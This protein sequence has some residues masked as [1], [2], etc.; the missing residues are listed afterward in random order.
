MKHK[1][2][3]FSLA[4][5]AA[6]CLLLGIAVLAVNGHVKRSAG[7][8][9]LSDADAAALENVDCILVLGCG[10]REDGSPSL[11]LRDRLDKIGRAHV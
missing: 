6:L 9:I 3:L 2:L 5:L 11:M 10:V 8:Y 7:Q 4:I 1:K